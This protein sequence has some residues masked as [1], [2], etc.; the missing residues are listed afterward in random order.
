MNI[1]KI[2]LLTFLIS[3]FL[4]MEYS[5]ST[6][7]EFIIKNNYINIENAILKLSDSEKS[8]VA[9]GEIP[10][11]AF[12]E[13]DYLNY[14]TDSIKYS[15]N[16]SSVYKPKEIFVKDTAYSAQLNYDQKEKYIKTHTLRE[17]RLTMVSGKVYSNVR[18]SG[19]NDSTVIVLKNGNAKVIFIKNIS[20]IKISGSGFWKGAMLGSGSALLI[21][22]FAGTIDTSYEHL[23]DGMK[24]GLALALPLA[25]VGGI[26]E[27]NE[28]LYYLRNMNTDEK[29][30][31]FEY[32]FRKY[33]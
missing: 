13:H 17:C 2:I 14:Q 29:K 15:E 18:L 27:S 19:L 4:N 28:A 8:S 31:S 6:G 11:N 32:L 22:F 20:S 1:F 21:G 26:I 16:S 24:I 12:N 25:I 23:W 5:F 10:V 3:G 30:K 33:K 9:I 7:S